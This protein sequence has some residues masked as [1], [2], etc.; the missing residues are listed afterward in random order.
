MSV[1]GIDIGGSAT[2]LAL[3]D[4]AGAV[5]HFRR[6][7]TV[8]PLNAFLDSVCGHAAALLALGGVTAVGVSVAGFIDPA[9]SRM[10]Y[11][12]N[13]PWLENVPLQSI[14]QDRLH[15]PVAIEVD[16][17]AAALA[18]SRFGAGAGADRFLSLTIGTGIGAGFV[19]DGA[20]ARFTGECIGDAGHIIVA[21]D[22]PLCA[23]GARGCAEAVA[24]GPAIAAEKR[25]AEAGRFIGLLAASLAA[26]F[27]PD[28]IALGGGVA[29]ASSEVIENARAEYL[30]SAGD[31][32][33]SARIVSALL[34]P[35]AP[36]V[37]AACPFL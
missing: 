8:P 13:L 19:S 30:H 2:K 11:N 17:N 6:V 10:V 15:T 7:P 23:C 16:S 4:S 32:V 24:A 37:G 22:G 3:I 14:F 25:H 20:L 27:F 31:A 12:P 29:H 36:L 21:P 33:R 26:L 35:N 18:E 28:C 34:G 1:C 9:H 5:H